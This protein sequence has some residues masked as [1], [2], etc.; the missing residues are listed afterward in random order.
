MS[1]H[2]RFHNTVLLDGSLYADNGTT[3]EIKN[4]QPSDSGEYKCRANNEVRGIY[5]N[6]ATLIVKGTATSKYNEVII[7]LHK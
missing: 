4:V 5:S 3:L 6:A 7:I 1:T 2:F